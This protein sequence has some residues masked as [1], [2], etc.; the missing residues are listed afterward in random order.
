MVWIYFAAIAAVI[1]FAGSRLSV[2][3][4]QLAGLLK[5]SRSAVGILLVSFVTTLPELS[6]T[7][8]AIIKVGEPNLALG[9][10]LGSV[11]FNLMIIA[12]CDI[13]FRKG[14][15]LRKTSDY[16]PCVFHSM[17]LLILMLLVL[18][19]HN[20]VSL[21][22][23][24][25]AG[26]S[27]L[28]IAAYI[29]IFFTTHRN[30][31]T[32]HEQVLDEFQT[33]TDQVTHLDDRHLTLAKALTGFV[34]SAVIVV[35]SGITLASIGNQ[36][37]ETTGLGQSFVG[38]LFLAIATSLPELAVGITSVKIGAYDLMIGNVAG[39]NMLNVLV[40]AVA[41]LVHRKEALHIPDNLSRSQLLTGFCAI[42]VTL[43]VMGAMK[44]KKKS[45]FGFGWESIVMPGIYIASLYVLYKG[46]LC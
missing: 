16:V 37:A 46:F 4:D 13:I 29:A 7:M 40:I 3:A 32:H 30:G 44:Q 6:T 39:A 41:D 35:I 36:I 34:I 24:N 5:L 25:F 9:N 26:G 2:F 12:I 31:G 21:F 45:R 33:V 1:I 14:G 20:T 11:L 18:I 43:L 23:F 22:G 19:A 8:G 10:N 42:L 15:I 17:L 38:T 28:V 27:V